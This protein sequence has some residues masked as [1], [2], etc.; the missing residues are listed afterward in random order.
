MPKRYSDETRT[1]ALKI[2]YSGVS[3]N[4]VGKIFNMH[5]SN[6]MRW[7]KKNPVSVDI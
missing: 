6:V 5:H 1:L 2:Y 4:G 3:G 7:I